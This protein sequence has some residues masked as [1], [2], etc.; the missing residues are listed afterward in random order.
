[1]A[2]RVATD[3]GGTFTDLVY[4]DEDT[5]Q[6]HLGKESTTPPHFEQGVATVLDRA[7]LNG[8]ASVGSFVHG[9]TVVINALTER[10]GSPTALI[11]TKGF[12]DVLELG[13]S[14]RP[15]LFNLR[16][17]K[18]EPFVERYLRFEIGERISVDGEILR[19]LNE[20]EVLDVVRQ[21]RKLGIVSVAICFL[22][23]YANP[24][25]EERCPDRRRRLM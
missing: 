3:I 6:V 13:R 17:R 2:I 15:A 19:P 10:S 8:G 5:G 7:A 18:P 24:V 16:Y 1:M 25:H 12:R 9:T 14:N 21:I 20:D 23:S 22:H 11:T 4:I